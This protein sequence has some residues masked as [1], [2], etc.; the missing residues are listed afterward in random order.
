M[1]ILYHVASG[2]CQNATAFAEGGGGKSTAKFVLSGYKFQNDLCYGP[3][4]PLPKPKTCSP[5]YLPGMGVGFYREGCGI[6]GRLN[7]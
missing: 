1:F 2:V 4:V 5:V 3:K 6:R 7:L